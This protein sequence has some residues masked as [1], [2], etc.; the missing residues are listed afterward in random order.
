LT[1]TPVSVEEALTNGWARNHALI[2][3]A[4]PAIPLPR[5]GIVKG[6]ANGPRHQ[7]E[8]VGKRPG[9]CESTKYPEG[10]VRP[11]EDSPFVNE[12]DAVRKVRG[13]DGRQCTSRGLGRQRGELKMSV[14]ITWNDEPH[15]RGAEIADAVKEHEGHPLAAHTPVSL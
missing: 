1:N 10:S 11:G 13:R 4:K 15:G 6:V 5:H 9:K 12:H 2:L 3:A 14:G 7:N 8:T